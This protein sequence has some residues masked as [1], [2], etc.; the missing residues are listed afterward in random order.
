MHYQTYIP[1][2]LLSGYVK[3]YWCLETESSVP[4]SKE[5]VFP[6][7]CTELI[8]HYGDLFKKYTG[9]TAAV[10][11]RSFIHGQIRSFIE[12][13][14]SGK[15]GIFSV[16]FHPNG[17]RAFTPVDISETTGEHVS[18][19]H[20]WGRAGR[21]LEDKILHAA[22]HA[23]RVQLI[24]AFLLGRLKVDPDDRLI[25]HC[26]QTIIQSQG[27]VSIEELATK[28][29]I[30]RRQLERRF[31]AGVGLSPKLLSR[32]TRFQNVLGLIE[33]K[34]FSSLTQLAYEGGFYDQAHFIKDFREFTGLNPRQYFSANLEMAKYF[35]LD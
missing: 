33:N 26:V 22:T 9:N 35:N 28:M 31:V 2:P 30:G 5:R 19:H 29:Y 11:P 8:F 14:A 12:I 34:Q 27:N 20:F 15:T 21:E 6:D 25:D 24:D 32:I 3:C 10:Q 1:H 16:R 7:G 4:L 18:I 23:Q 13:E 17:L